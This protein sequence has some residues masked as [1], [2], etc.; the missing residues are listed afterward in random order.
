MAFVL[1]DAK[2]WGGN[3]GCVQRSAQQVGWRSCTNT[4]KR[5]RIK[6]N[7]EGVSK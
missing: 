4:K 7:R 6:S 1:A 2:N 5:V 3:P